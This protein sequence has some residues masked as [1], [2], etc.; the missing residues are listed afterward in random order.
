M[1]AGGITF[2]PLEP[3][4]NGGRRP[5]GGFRGRRPG[6]ERLRGRELEERVCGLCVEEPYKCQLPHHRPPGAEA[7]ALPG[8]RSPGCCHRPKPRA[9]PARPAHTRDFLF[10]FFLARWCSFGGDS[11]AECRSRGA[12]GIGGRG[13]GEARGTPRSR[14]S[15]GKSDHRTVTAAAKETFSPLA[16]RFQ[17]PLPT[18]LAG[19]L[20]T[21]LQTGSLAV[22]G[23]QPGRGLGESSAYGGALVG[24]SRSGACFLLPPAHHRPSSVQALGRL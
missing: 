14:A 3:G 8:R 20:S 6:V 15:P 19:S 12:N 10:S 1:P 16:A 2:L 4:V 7:R 18:Q 21:F 13:W 9:S 11:F 17:R 5:L 22:T 23:F 24:A